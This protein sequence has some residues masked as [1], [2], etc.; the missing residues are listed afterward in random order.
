MHD[1]AKIL[2]ILE[3]KEKQI[4]YRLFELEQRIKDL[5]ILYTINYNKE[6]N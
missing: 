1:V 5:T 6:V 3:E 4:K 2:K